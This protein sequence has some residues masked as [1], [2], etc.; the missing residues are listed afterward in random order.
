M[1]LTE[2][3]AEAIYNQEEHKPEFAWELRPR[4]VKNAYIAMAQSILSTV[5]DWLVEN[6]PKDSKLLLPKSGADGL[7]NGGQD[8][9]V[10]IQ[11]RNMG[12]EE[13]RTHIKRE[14]GKE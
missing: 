5:A 3:V 4:C 1:T 13:Y 7:G 10:L 9:N 6:G 2:A 8:V 11:G 12:L 14:C